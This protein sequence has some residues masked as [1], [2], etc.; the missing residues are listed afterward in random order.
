MQVDYQPFIDR[1]IHRYEGGFG[2]NHKDPGGPTNFGITC[3]DLAEHRGQK[4]TSMAA[5][6]APVRDMSLAEAEAIYK[7]KYATAIRFD[8]LPAGPDCV[9]LD[10]G[11]NSGSGRPIDVARVLCKCTG[12]TGRMDSD[13]LDAIRKVD[14][15]WFVDQ[16][17][18]ERLRFMHAIRGGSAWVEFGHGWQARV[19]DL[20]AYGEHLVAGGTHETAPPAPDLSKVVTP[21]AQH[22]PNTASGK[23]A[24]GAIV[25]GAAAHAAGLPLWGVATACAGVLAAG[26]AYELWQEHRALAAN[27]LVHA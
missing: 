12:N 19:D 14:P 15:K 20:R 13:L 10:Y 4:M 2:W 9:M 18:A 1:V 7:T 27:N 24:G 25:I 5:W 6:E 11:I 26:V 16:M 17:C 8:A 23:T 22:V 3:Y 21:K